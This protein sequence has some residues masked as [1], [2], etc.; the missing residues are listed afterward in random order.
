MYLP[1]APRRAPAR[2]LYRYNRYPRL[3][4]PENAKTARNSPDTCRFDALHCCDT[5]ARSRQR[6]KARGGAD[7]VPVYPEKKWNRRAYDSREG[8]LKLR[9]YLVCD[10]DQEYDLPLAV[11]PAAEGEAEGEGEAAMEQE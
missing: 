10:S 4:K 6:G 5:L 11:L 2:A 3:C 1:R 8:Y 9:L 7:A